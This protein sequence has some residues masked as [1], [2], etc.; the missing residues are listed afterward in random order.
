MSFPRWFGLKIAL[1]DD[2]TAELL[3]IVS[4]IKKYSSGKPEPIEVSA[5]QS[6][7]ELLDA[8]KNKTF[9]ILFLDILMPG[10]TGMDAAKEIRTYNDNVAIVFLTSSAEFAVE[11]YNV[12]AYH[13]LIK[14]ASKE[15]IFPVLDKLSAEVKKADECL[16]IKTGSS[17]FVIPFKSIEYMEINAKKLYF[18]MTD[19]SVKEV[20]GKLS[21]YESSLLARPEFVKT[22]RSFILNMNHIN[23]L[24]KNEAIT[25]LGKRVLIS[26]SLYQTVRL[27]YTEFLFKEVKALK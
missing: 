26:R 14:P 5:F 7:A 24:N 18:F 10:I 22:H 1:C 16:K 17:V 6:G 21:D 3:N 13:Y 11:S 12:R 23:E 25:E 27:S 19:G 2:N 4:L 8:M 9:D 15:K 20:S